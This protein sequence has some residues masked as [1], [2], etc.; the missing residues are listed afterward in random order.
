LTAADRRAE[1][2]AAVERLINARALGDAYGFDIAPA[3]IPG[4]QGVAAGYLLIVS[5]RSPVLVPPRMAQVQVI[6]DAWPGDDALAAAVT[7]CMDGLAQA[8]ADLLKIPAQA[9]VNGN[10]HGAGLVR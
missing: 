2:S 3:L 8:K 5:C 9:A 10:G 1:L 6:P 7:A 4:P